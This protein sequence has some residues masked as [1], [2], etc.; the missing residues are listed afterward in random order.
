MSIRS[1]T[2]TISSVAGIASSVA[3]KLGALSNSGGDNSAIRERYLNGFLGN[4][5]QFTPSVFARAFDEPT[6][7]TFR[8]EFDFNRYSRVNQG[9]T[10]GED[11][12]A[13]SFNYMPEPLLALPDGSKNPV[14]TTSI[15]NAFK[16][17]DN[18]YSSYRYLRDALG[19]KRRAEM[20]KQFILSLHDIQYHYPYY[21]TSVEGLDSISSINTERGIRLLDGDNNKLTIKCLEGLDQKITQLMQLYRKAAWD[22]VYQRWILPDMMRFFTLRIYVS[23]MKLFHTTSKK[24]NKKRGSFLI[25]M[26]S[27]GSLGARSRDALQSSGNLL[28]GLNNFLNSAAA[29][30]ANMLGDGSSITKVLND[31][32]SIVETVDTVL[33][34]IRG[35][36]FLCDNAINEV[37]PTM[38]FECH[39][40]EFDISKTLSHISHLSS[41]KNGTTPPE[42]ELNI[43]V[44][45]LVEK[46]IF[47]LQKGLLLEQDAYKLGK[48]ILNANFISDDYLKKEAT[49]TQEEL[50]KED[51]TADYKPT[52]I[53][54]K[55]NRI[56]SVYGG[57]TS[58]D[59]FASST[60]PNSIDESYNPFS[61]DKK[62]AAVS[63]FTGLAGVFF[64]NLNSTAIDGEAAKAA[65]ERLSDTNNY[66]QLGEATADTV[67][68]DLAKGY[69]TL[70]DEFKT[71]NDDISYSEA[72]DDTVGRKIAKDSSMLNDKFK[73]VNN[74][75]S[76]SEA[77][78]D[79]VG[80]GRAKDSSMLDNEYK[81]VNDNVSYSEA[82]HDTVGIKRV[83]D[84][85]TLNDNDASVNKNISYSEAV[86]NTTR[87]SSVIS[88]ISAPYSPVSKTTIDGSIIDNVTRTSPTISG[89]AL[90]DELDKA[91]TSTA[92]SSTNKIQ[93]IVIENGADAVLSAATA[94][95]KTIDFFSDN[96]EIKSMATSK[97]QQET[98][99][100]DL[101]LSALETISLSTATDPNSKA[102]KDLAT[103][104]LEDA[105]FSLAT[106]KG[107][108]DKIS[109]TPFVKDPGVSS[110]TSGKLKFNTGTDSFSYLNN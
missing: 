54:Y 59:A 85:S 16:V 94:L 68:R 45:R 26:E 18:F 29:I 55:H 35:D 51:G 25:D 76:Y 41:S 20:L 90:F 46:M 12:A 15:N 22:D 101:M 2:N 40:C 99:T 69:S 39:M 19:E 14:E 63:L 47:P 33:N 81:T 107:Y 108:S 65:K 9:S 50:A 23:E 110:A 66:L 105:E 72:V 80:R 87:R 27:T 49:H 52:A 93:D 109:K 7:L 56:N 78:D 31:A 106:S 28:G 62:T 43:K 73:T 104:M 21:F 60:S 84:S 64:T 11:Y 3:T 100:N 8:I 67:K 82:I 71:V 79:T 83:K 1:V 97:E 92:V 95:K 44:G 96:E 102:L 32:D 17:K 37:M 57:K 24:S 48:S 88:A 86:N 74:N 53:S 77:V 89:K 34:S 5:S 10:T 42:P 6:Y 70:N 4:T 75:I 38:C 91:V 103:V 58:H 61:P 98:V 36:L 30:S 13:D